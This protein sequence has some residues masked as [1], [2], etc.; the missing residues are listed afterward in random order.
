MLWP[1]SMPYWGMEQ[2]SHHCFEI[3]IFQSK[4]LLV[5]REAL[6]DSVIRQL[7]RLRL[8]SYPVCRQ[9]DCSYYHIP[10][11]PSQRQLQDCSFHAD[12]GFWWHKNY[13]IV[14]FLVSNSGWLLDDLQSNW[15]L[16][17]LLVQPGGKKCS[18]SPRKS[19]TNVATCSIFYW[20]ISALPKNLLNEYLVMIPLKNVLKCLSLF[21]RPG[22]LVSIWK[23]F[24]GKFQ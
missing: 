13:W 3:S 20:I 12:V 21:H 14:K 7:P 10:L 8:L 11:P 2:N 17:I 19:L 9:H 22:F 15:L 24:F 6:L 5:W 23:N 1:C 4:T 18:L 16:L